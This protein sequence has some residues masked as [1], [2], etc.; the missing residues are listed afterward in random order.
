MPRLITYVREDEHCGCTR[1][2]I[3]CIIIVSD[4]IRTAERCSFNIFV[5]HRVLVGIYDFS[6]SRHPASVLSERLEGGWRKIT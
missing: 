4:E 2:P 6:V 1:V 5:G 3:N